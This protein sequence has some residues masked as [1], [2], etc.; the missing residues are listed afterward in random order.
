LFRLCASC[1]AKLPDTGR[2]LR[3]EYPGVIYHVLNR[4]DRREPIFRIDQDRL[5]FLDT[6]AARLR[7]E[8]TMT[9]TWIT[10]RLNM[11]APGSLANLLRR[12]IKK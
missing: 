1:L 8:T 2:K 6:L 12:A 4:G 11:G 3:V 10:Q 7:R 5:L 9:L